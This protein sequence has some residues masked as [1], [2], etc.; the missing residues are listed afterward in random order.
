MRVL[1][2]IAVALVLLPACSCGTDPCGGVQAGIGAPP[3]A[4]EGITLAPLQLVVANDTE[5]AVLDFVATSQGCG[6]NNVTDSVEVEVRDPNNDDVEATFDLTKADDST[7]QPGAVRVRFKPKMLG[8]HHVKARFSPLGG[9]HQQAV[10]VVHDRRQAESVRL[11][12]ECRR[13]VRTASDQY[14]CDGRAW[15]GDGF[16][17]FFVSQN[18]QLAASGDV[19]WTVDDVAREVRRFEAADG[20]VSGSPN[21]AL[22]FS[23]SLSAFAATADEGIGMAIDDL[24]LFRYADGGLSHVANVRHHGDAVAARAVYRSGAD[25]FAAF[26]NQPLTFPFEQRTTVCVYRVTASD[27]VPPEDAGTNTPC[28]SFTGS[29]YS[30]NRDGLWLWSE[31]S[32]LLQLVT[33]AGADGGLVVFDSAS[34]T[35]TLQVVRGRTVFGSELPHF[36]Y[37]RLDDFNR[38]TTPTTLVPR[39][40]D[41]RIVFDH[42]SMSPDSLRSAQDN[43]VFG[44]GFGETFAIAR[45]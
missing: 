37:Q 35:Q 1:P 6:E 36:G 16:G 3:P 5:D 34:M 8:Q 4:K 26:E 19:I 23:M 18:A 25:V 2:A 38:V 43:L 9:T 30:A 15:T 44:V 29:P 14:I 11:N 41:R 12:V 27:L 21:N 28:W 32:Q 45:D 17:P 42:F 24:H 10:L 22:P 13:M 31:R 7:G 40:E 33:N 39:V 20:G